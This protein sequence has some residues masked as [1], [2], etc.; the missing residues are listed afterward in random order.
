ML[1]LHQ[2]LEDHF[3]HV[4]FDNRLAGKIHQ[5]NLQYVSQNTQHLEFFG[6]NLLGVQVIRY[7]DS[8]L[9]R[10]YDDVLNVD[11][12]DLKN[13]IRQ[14]K[15]IDHSRKVS[16]DILNITCMYLIFKFN[17][18]SI[19]DPDRKEKAVYDSAALF[20]IRC[21][22]AILSDWIKYA[23]DPSVAKA[24]YARLSNKHLI[25][26][27]GSWQK[28]IDYRARDLISEEGIHY[29]ILNSFNDDN[30]I[31]YLIN[32]SQG[33]IRDLLK[34]YYS[35]FKKALD[36]GEKIGSN[37]STWFDAD[38][39][40][41]IKDK[42][43]TVESDVTYMESIIADKHSFVKENLLSIIISTNKNTS[44]KM[45][46]SV[47]AWMS[48]EYHNHTY[49]QLIDDFLSKT[50]IYSYYL[51]NDHVQPSHLRDYPYILTQ[52]KN[53]YLSTRSEDSD[54]LEIRDL[55]NK[56]I[57]NS[58]DGEISD[59]LLT[60]TRTSIILYLILRSLVGKNA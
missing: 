44:I 28:V 5:Y 41:T 59:A 8:D 32:D 30:A 17:K 53:L 40:E 4:K 60:A 43:G 2:V 38:G 37:S 6:G 16:S 20:F 57:K 7:K 42:I 34:N 1:T 50:L 33:R 26:R 55:G 21:L 35:E 46:R 52:L 36:A 51:I 25:K 11:Y 47:L 3:K 49:K 23:T 29:K 13:D 48:D 15:T 31:V 27:L 19:I 39:E 58:K 18:S 10:F 14:V 24:A 22:A 12:E 56:I 54:L 9:N 45:V